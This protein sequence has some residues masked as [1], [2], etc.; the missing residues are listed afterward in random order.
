MEYETIDYEPSLKLDY[1]VVRNMGYVMSRKNSVA[2]ARQRAQRR[3]NKKK[4]E[5]LLVL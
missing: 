5:P 1:L 3:R 4:L 2:L